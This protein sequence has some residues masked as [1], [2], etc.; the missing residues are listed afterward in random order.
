MN[1]E[2]LKGMTFSNV[3]RVGDDEI[4]FTEVSGRKFKLYH[5]QDCCEK[6]TI[7]DVCGDLNDLIGH[8]ILH[9]IGS[10]SELD[11][12][13]SHETFTFYII[14]TIKGTVTMRWYGESNGYYSE[15]VY[16][17]EIT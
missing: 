2:D 17:A 13:Y 14:D 15:A 11:G 4:I 12:E 8:P 9:A 3:E 7:E 6:V 1:F 5:E 10:S 16:F